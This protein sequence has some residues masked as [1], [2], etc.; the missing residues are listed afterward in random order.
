MLEV[1][2]IV[3]VTSFTSN[4]EVLCAALLQKVVLRSSAIDADHALDA[5]VTFL[6][7][8]TFSVARSGC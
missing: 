4:C 8:W 1:N 3:A 7:A 2:G 6:L 5:K